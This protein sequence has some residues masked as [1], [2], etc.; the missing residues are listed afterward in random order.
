MGAMSLDERV[1]VYAPLG[2]DGEV[3]QQILSAAGVSS[4]VYAVSHTLFAA[5]EE[6]AAALVLTEETLTQQT[7]D[8]L[9]ARL[10]S[11][12]PWSD[13]TGDFAAVGGDRGA[14]PSAQH[15]QAS[16]GA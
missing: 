4:E 2:R 11:Q 10:A 14:I 15:I 5:L 8:R 9:L 13:S 7:R 1:L 16:A 3:I 12:P 6:G